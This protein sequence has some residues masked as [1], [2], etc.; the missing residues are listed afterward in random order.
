MAIAEKLCFGGNF[1]GVF[2]KMRIFLK[3]LAS[4][5]FDPQHPLTSCK[6][7]E[8]TYEPILRKTVY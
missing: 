4:S 2:T 8:K 1:G 7:S 5:V 3:N 6:I